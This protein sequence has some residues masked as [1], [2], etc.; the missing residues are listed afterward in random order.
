MKNLKTTILSVCIALC[1]LTNGNTQGHRVG[2]LPPPL[3]PRILLSFGGGLSS[4]SIEAKDKAFLSNTTAINADVFLPLISK[5]INENGKG[6]Q[7][8]G[9]NR[10]SAGLNFGGAYNFGG[11]G[12]FGTT[13]NP[14]AITG[15]TSSMVSDKTVDP[16]SPGFRMGGG[17]QAN[18]YFGKFIVSPMVLGEY[19]SMTQKE[20]SIVQT[21]QYNGL[22]YDFNL[23]TLPETKTSGFAVT[24]KLRLQYMISKHFGLFADASYT[25]GPKMETTVSKL[26][27]NGNPLVDLQSY[28]LQ[29]LQTGT[30]VKGETKSTAY[31]AM[32]FNFG[33]VIGWGGKNT[34]NQKQRPCDCCHE[35]HG[36]G[37]CPNGCDKATSANVLDPKDLVLADAGKDVV[38]QADVKAIAE[39]LVTMR[40]GWD[41]SIKGNIVEK[42]GITENGLKKNEAK[43]E[44]IN[45]NLTS[46]AQTL[47][48]LA[49]KGWDGSIKGNKSESV[50]NEADVKAITETLVN[51]RKGWDGSIKGNYAESITHEADVK[52]IT[53][54]FVNI[55]KGWDGSIKG[56]KN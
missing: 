50:A 22:S 7:E 17:P 52:A 46:T 56:N 27:P 31:S 9:L 16:R 49:R 26:I 12:G 43:S 3:P 32:G 25:T 1:C 41:G 11:S 23:A 24:P 34:D 44:D 10:F 47:V 53:E 18:F 21:T 13:P 15:Q 39:T 55:R 2:Y 40:K 35:T 37:I 42:K 54:V 20:M 8:G 33:V 14:F 29:Q 6:I 51:I 38:N 45:L 30:M 28:N 5:G 19:F 36:R 4:P 48:N